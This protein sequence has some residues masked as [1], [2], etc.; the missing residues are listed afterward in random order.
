MTSAF[1]MR[2][3]VSAA[4]INVNKNALLI[5]DVKNDDKQNIGKIKQQPSCHSQGSVCVVFAFIYKCHGIIFFFFFFLLHNQINKGERVEIGYPLNV[6]RHR[7]ASPMMV[8]VDLE[9]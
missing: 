6:L 4:K 7:C 3:P 2:R 1:N 5:I 8:A 9:R